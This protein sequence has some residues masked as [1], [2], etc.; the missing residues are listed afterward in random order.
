LR[1]ALSNRHLTKGCQGVRPVMCNRFLEMSNIP[2]P[3]IKIMFTKIL[4]ALDD[5]EHS[6]NVFAEAL[7]LAQQFNAKLLLL[8]VLSPSFEDYPEMPLVADFGVYHYAA[9]HE[10]A[11]KRHVEHCAALE[12]QGLEK[13]RSLATEA[14]HVDVVAEFSQNLGEPGRTICEMARNWQ[15]DLIAIGRRGRNKL[16]E[17]FLGSVSNYVLH[18]APCSVLT[19]QGLAIGQQDTEQM[20]AIVVKR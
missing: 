16:S 1:I 11:I 17:F 8:H 6:R 4:V 9:L 19:V 12:R 10:D 15:A 2:F 20:P 14:R 3:Q 13:L 7:T 5:S 18:H